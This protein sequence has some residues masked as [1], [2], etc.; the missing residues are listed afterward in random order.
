MPD[1]S[2][3]EPVLPRCLIDQSLLAFSPGRPPLNPETGAWNPSLADRYFCQT[4]QRIYRLE[5]DGTLIWKGGT[6][7]P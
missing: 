4:C 7:M 5:D 1:N 2:T 6:P 3:P